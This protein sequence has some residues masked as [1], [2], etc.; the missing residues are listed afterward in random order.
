MGP[1]AVALTMPGSAD[2][3]NSG[4]WVEYHCTANRIASLQSLALDGNTNR[5]LRERVARG[6]DTIVR[7]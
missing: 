1:T 6:S 2:N 7:D 3:S 5:K 4:L